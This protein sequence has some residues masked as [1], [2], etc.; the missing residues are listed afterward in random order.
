MLLA[1]HGEFC[2]VGAVPRAVPSADGVCHF[3]AQYGAWSGDSMNTCRS[4]LGTL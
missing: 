4:D 3:R 2:C 1:H